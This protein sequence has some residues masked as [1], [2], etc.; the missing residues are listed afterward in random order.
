VVQNQQTVYAIRYPG[1]PEKE[2][3]R[4]GIAARD[5]EGQGAV[6]T[7]ILPGSPATQVYDISSK[8]FISLQA[9]QVLISANGKSISKFDDLIKIVSE[10]PQ[11]MRIGIRDAN[12]GD[13]ECLLRM[14]Y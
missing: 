4:T 7:A 13:F 14:R 12:R 6:I 9:Q 5:F 3:P 2:G 1:M 11:I 8:Q 10:S